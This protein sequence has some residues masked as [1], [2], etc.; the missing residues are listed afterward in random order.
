M[1]LR[2]QH[3]EALIGSPILASAS[4]VTPGFSIYGDS[5]PRAML[6]RILNIFNDDSSVAKSPPSDDGFNGYEGSVFVALT[7]T[8][9]VL[10]ERSILTDTF[11]N[12]L[13]RSER[14]STSIART[15]K[16]EVEIV[17]ANGQVFRLEPQDQR[18]NIEKLIEMATH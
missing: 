10:L 4:F 7:E 1:S 17:F 3:A 12:E 9:V 5:R 15:S 14:T 6:W 11:N 8:T 16:C 2:Q 18:K 13:A